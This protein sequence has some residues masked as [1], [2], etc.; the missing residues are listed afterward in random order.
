MPYIFSTSARI[1]RSCSPS[2][3][4][5]RSLIELI[6]TLTI[7]NLAGNYYGFDASES[8][9][10]ADARAI[11]SDWL[12]TGQDIKDSIAEGA[13]NPKQLELQLK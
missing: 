2:F 7:W 12:M 6:V 8:E 10:E 1:M 9:Q 5:I 4:I 3:V 11:L 13:K